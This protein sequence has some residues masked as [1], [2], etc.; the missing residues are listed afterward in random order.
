MAKG[1]IQKVFDRKTRQMPDWMIAFVIEELKH[2]L[3][4]EIQ[5]ELDSFSP[6]K[7]YRVSMFRHWLIGD[8]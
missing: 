2:E 7:S 6:M 4:I 5:K 8:E 1:L 3:V